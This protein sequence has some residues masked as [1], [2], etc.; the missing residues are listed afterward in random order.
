MDT[1][2]DERIDV[3]A[4]FTKSKLIPTFFCWRKRVFHIQEV[5]LTHKVRKG[6][7]PWYFFSVVSE[8]NLYRLGF[9]VSSFSWRLDD[10]Q[11]MDAV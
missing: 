9:D 6:N 8:G 2:I 3:G 5:T 1:S 11:P 7:V 10:V 4:V